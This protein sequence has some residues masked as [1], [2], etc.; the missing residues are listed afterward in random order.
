MRTGGHNNLCGYFQVS[1]S[2]RNDWVEDMS[3]ENNQAKKKYPSYL[4]WSG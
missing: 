1:G 4:Y 3:Y 2:I